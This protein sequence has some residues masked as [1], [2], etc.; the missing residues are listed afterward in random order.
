MQIQSLWAGFMLK[1]Y[2]SLDSTNFSDG[3]ILSYLIDSK[4]Q[5]IL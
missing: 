4:T 1:H 3:I 5:Q 2:F